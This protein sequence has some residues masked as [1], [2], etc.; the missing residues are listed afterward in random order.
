M[1]ALVTDWGTM[2]GQ[3]A[4]I[5]YTPGKGKKDIYWGG[6]GGYDGSGKNHA[7]VYDNDP[8]NMHYLR[9]NG[10][11]MV[12]AA[13]PENMGRKAETRFQ[14]QLRKQGGWSGIFMT[15][16]RRAWRQYFG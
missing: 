1:V 2:D 6:R 5:V 16:W 11:I 4:K 8:H 7:V 13:H 9:I 14:R 10:Q 3:P 12:D 15:A